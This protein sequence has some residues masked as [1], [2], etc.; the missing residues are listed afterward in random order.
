MDEIEQVA[1][2][3]CRER[4]LD[5]DKRI[6]EFGRTSW[7]YPQWEDFRFAAIHQIK[8]EKPPAKN[9]G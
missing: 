5:P 8:Q 4:G 3:M 9:R 1:R 2:E 7:S 6:K